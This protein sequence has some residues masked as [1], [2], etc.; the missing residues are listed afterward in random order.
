MKTVEGETSKVCARGARKYKPANL[1]TVQALPG[2]PREYFRKFGRADMHAGD[3]QRGI[4][5]GTDEVEL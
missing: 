1:T 5:P 4:R 2:R 3:G